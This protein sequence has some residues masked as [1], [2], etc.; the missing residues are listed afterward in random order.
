LRR[1]IKERDADGVLEAMTK[2]RSTFTQAELQRAVNKEIYPRTGADDGE[3]RSVELERAQF[4]NAALS[5]PEIVQLRDKPEIGPTTRYTTRNVL[6]AES[7]VLRATN[8][9]KTDTG[10][11]VDEDRRA[12]VLAGTYGTMSAEQAHAFRHCTGDEG[13]A[14]IDGQAGTGKS[15]TMAAIRD[16]Y[17]AAG[18]R[19]I[20]LAPTNKVAKNL[21]N[22]GFEHAKTV[23]S[24]L[25]ALNNG[26]T[27]W[28][29]KPSSWWTKR[30]CSTPDFMPWWR[31]TRM[32][33]ARS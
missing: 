4:M 10:H 25:F 5:H 14:L 33:P 19:V 15:F 24:E 31:R 9:L 22:D 20:G 27:R 13:L 30:R 6:E 2:Q 8:G 18:H 21:A 28:D 11:G 32:T 26:R 17:K 12:A 7:H 23:H 29:P 3:K 1:A 16:A